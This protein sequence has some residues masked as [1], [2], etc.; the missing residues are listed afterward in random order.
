MI[1]PID[2]DCDPIAATQDL[3]EKQ[4]EI[5]NLLNMMRSPVSAIAIP[6]PNDDCCGVLSVEKY[7]DRPTCNECGKVY[8]IIEVVD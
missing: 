4:G 7:I 5:I 3:W 2:L 8:K 6:C 1:E